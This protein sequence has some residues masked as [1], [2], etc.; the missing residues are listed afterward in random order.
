MPVT[1]TKPKIKL[2]CGCM[3]RR[4]PYGVYELLQCDLHKAAPDLLAALRYMLPLAEAY[5]S[6]APSHPDNAKLEDA[7]AAIRKA[8]GE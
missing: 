1:Y 3:V 6:G 7:R 5:L 8:K 4:S 2:A